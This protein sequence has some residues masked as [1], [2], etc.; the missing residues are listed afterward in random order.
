MATKGLI[1]DV[2]VIRTG[3]FGFCEKGP[4][5]NVLPDN[6]FYVE[7]KPDDAQEIIDEHIIKGRRV[8][9][10][11]YVNPKTKSISP[12][13]NT[14]DST[15]NNCVSL[16]VIAVWWTLKNIE[17]S[18]A[19]DAYQALGKVLT[20]MSQNDAIEIIKKSGLRGRGAVTSTGLKWE[21]TKNSVSDKKYVV[22]NA[23]FSCDPV[24]LW[25]VPSSREIRT[26]SS[27]PWPFAVIA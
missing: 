12:T 27:K 19:H 11:L 17:E 14:W 22:C 15:K 18:I 21:I 2:Q 9:R 3:C 20:E 26:P 10:L 25:T 13:P 6:T 1:E 7:V 5:V 8:N 23:N 4:I 16:C 24:H